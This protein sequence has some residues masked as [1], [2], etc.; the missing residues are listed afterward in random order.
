MLLIHLQRGALKIGQFFYY[1]LL[2]FVV[3]GVLSF[4]FPAYADYS[5]AGGPGVSN[6]QNQTSVPPA[7]TSLIV[8]PTGTALSAADMITHIA[9][10]IP[11]LM[12]LVTALAYVLGMGFIFHGVLA[13]K[14]YGEQRTMMSGQPHLKGPLIY[15]TV[16]TLLLYLPTSVQVGVSTFWTEPNPYGY[17]QQQDQWSQFL[18]NCYM[19]VQL[20]GIIAFIRGLVILTHL[21]GHGGQPGTLAK[22][23]T[24]IIGGILCIN[25]YQFVQVIMITLGI[26]SVFSGS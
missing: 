15:I 8:S 4:S 25:I 13:L 6:T 3:A 14:H 10:Q 7:E 23:M 2:S 18:N 22:G 9:S 24:H 26:Q 5:V 11:N 16:G 20:F 1:L 19:V 12:R 17:L 21:G